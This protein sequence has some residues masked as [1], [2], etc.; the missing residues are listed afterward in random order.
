MLQICSFNRHITDDLVAQHLSL[1]I[2]EHDE[3]YK[4]VH[5][6]RFSHPV[7]CWS[8][9]HVATERSRAHELV[10]APP[11][12]FSTLHMYNLLN[13]SLHITEPSKNT[14]TSLENVEVDRN[15]GSK[16]ALNVTVTPAAR[17]PRT[18]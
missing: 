10:H 9:A 6:L 14:V 8:H 1:K 2:S 17:A 16:V 4:C 11:A 5:T 12:H 13:Q 18:S 7:F 3:Q 15:Q